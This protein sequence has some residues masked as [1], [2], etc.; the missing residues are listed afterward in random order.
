MTNRELQNDLNLE[1]R[2][3]ANIGTFIVKDNKIT[4]T[5]AKHLTKLYG[6]K[7]IERDI[8]LNELDKANAYTVDDL[9]H[10]FEHRIITYK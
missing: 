7:V 2:D 1:S 9:M 3:W 4:L 5:V 8:T 10:E 6:V